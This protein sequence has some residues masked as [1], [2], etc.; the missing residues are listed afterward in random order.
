MRNIF[1]DITESIKENWG[2]IVVGV[3]LLIVL[4]LTMSL[5]GLSFQD[6][7]DDDKPKKA[8]D[9]IE[10]IYEGMYNKFDELCKDDDLEKMC[11]GLG[12]GKQK[13]CN[14]VQCCVWAENKNGGACVE[15]D[16]MGPMIKEDNNKMKYDEYYYLNKKF[17]LK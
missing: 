10:F 12:H 4:L 17:K 9:T 14:T 3:V 1:A 7:N 11:K 13:S 2:E 6:I 16:N 8:T 15:G 5:Y